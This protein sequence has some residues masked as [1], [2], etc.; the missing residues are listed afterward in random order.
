MLPSGRSDSTHT[1]TGLCPVLAV[2]GPSQTHRSRGRLRLC[3]A[4]SPVARAVSSSLS[5]RT[6]LPLP[7]APH[8]ALP[9]R[10]CLPLPRALCLPEGNDFH[11]LSSWFHGRTRRGRRPREFGVVSLYRTIRRDLG[12]RRGL[13]EAAY[14]GTR[15]LPALT[16]LLSRLDTCRGL[17]ELPACPRWSE[18]RSGGGGALLAGS[19]LCR[20]L[21]TRSRSPQTSFR[22]LDSSRL[23]A[24][25]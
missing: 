15:V 21:P 19:C 23:R 3:L 6:N 4:G 22:G 7:A 2:L 10:S 13:S 25:A 11:I 1:R 17:G 5:F 8:P 24:S 18:T 16:V 9:R 14:N 20:E 12:S